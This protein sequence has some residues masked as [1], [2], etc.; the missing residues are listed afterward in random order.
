MRAKLITKILLNKNA[1]LASGK[2]LLLEGKSQFKFCNYQQMQRSEVNK[3]EMKF[4]IK[5]CRERVGKNEL[6]DYAA[7]TPTYIHIR[8]YEYTK[9]KANQ[10]RSVKFT[11]CKF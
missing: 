7:E 5:F 9:T 4:L 1:K 2:K 6:L 3:G 10:G 11:M 8:V